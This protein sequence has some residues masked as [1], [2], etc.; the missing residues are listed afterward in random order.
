MKKENM[1]N[2]ICMILKEGETKYQLT[3]RTNT[4]DG[5]KNRK[6]EIR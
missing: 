2:E 6:A 4:G 1:K 3:G 5:I